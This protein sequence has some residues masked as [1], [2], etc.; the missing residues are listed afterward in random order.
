ME[1]I[2]SFTI[3][4]FYFMSSAQVQYAPPPPPKDYL[5]YDN[6]NYGAFAINKEYDISEFERQ[7]TKIGNYGY[8]S[9]IKKIVL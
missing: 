5:F 3:L 9:T 2:L 7:E 1:K 6:K 4:F 8:L